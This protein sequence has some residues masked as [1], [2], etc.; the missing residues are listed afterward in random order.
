MARYAMIKNGAVENIIEL[1]QA[2]EEEFPGCVPCGDYPVW[3]G[4][5]FQD[6]RFYREGQEIKASCQLLVEARRDADL[7]LAI[8]RGEEEENA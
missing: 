5:A 6:G 1:R 7:A 3:L 8:L 4:D 2:Q